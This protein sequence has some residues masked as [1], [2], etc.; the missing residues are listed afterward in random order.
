[1][2]GI[3]GIKQDGTLTALGSASGTLPAAGFNGLA[4]F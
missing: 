3:F 2:L 1:M 4:A